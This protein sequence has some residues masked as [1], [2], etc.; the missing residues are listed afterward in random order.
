MDVPSIQEDADANRFQALIQLT[1]QQANGK[2]ATI[3]YS[4]SL[5]FA[6]SAQHYVRQRHISKSLRKLDNQ[7]V[8]PD[9]TC[10]L[11]CIREF[12][13]ESRVKIRAK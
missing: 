11:H 8:F 6:C 4:N 9:L 5:S 7:I 2:I 3:D 13:Y 10:H 1:G 12:L